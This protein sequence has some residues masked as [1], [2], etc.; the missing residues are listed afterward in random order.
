LK[1]LPFLPG[2]RLLLRAR[3]AGWVGF[4]I[5][6]L[7]LMKKLEESGFTVRKPTK[8]PEAGY[9]VLGEAAVNRWGHQ[10]DIKQA[11]FYVVA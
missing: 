1:L 8:L 3:Q 2:N 7:Q 4:D 9:P 5:D 11:H 10:R 6:Q